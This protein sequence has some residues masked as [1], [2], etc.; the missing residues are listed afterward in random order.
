M[1]F[2]RQEYWSGLPFPSPGDLPDSGIKLRS[3]QWQADSLP[4]SHEGSPS[5]Q[6]TQLL[7][8]KNEDKGFLLDGNDFRFYS[9]NQVLCD[10]RKLILPWNVF[11]HLLLLLLLLSHWVLLDPFATPWTIARQASLSMGFPRQEYWNGLPFLSA[12][13][14]PKSGIE[15]TSSACQADSPGLSH[16]GSPSS[17][18]GIALITENLQVRLL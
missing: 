11:L 18:I 12:G 6:I 13:N 7:C 8:C 1:E 14:L 3:P 15:F 5:R 9:A 10:L 2:P 17:S 4:L 16:L